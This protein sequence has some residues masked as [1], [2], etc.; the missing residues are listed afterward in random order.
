LIR[1]SALALIHV[2][3]LAWLRLLFFSSRAVVNVCC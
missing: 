3:Y 1:P 2:S